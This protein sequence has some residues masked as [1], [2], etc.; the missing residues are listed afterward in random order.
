MLPALP[1]P[2]PLQIAVIVL[3]PVVPA[4]L[5]AFYVR[6]LEGHERE[7]WR[8]V[9]FAMVLGLAVGIAFLLPVALLLFEQFARESDQ[10]TSLRN[11]RGVLLLLVLLPLFEEAIKLA[12][13][14]FLKKE[15]NEVEDGLIYGVMVGAGFGIAE[16][17]IGGLGLTD[18]S[19]YLFVSLVALRGLSGV[20]LHANS[21]ALAGYGLSRHWVEK[22]SRYIVPYFLF[23]VGLHAL[24]NVFAFVQISVGG[25]DEGLL[26]LARLAFVLVLASLTF[27]YVRRRL[28]ELIKELDR[29]TDPRL[30][31]GGAQARQP[32]R[33]K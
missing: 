10:V 7:P 29:A 16:G 22:K 33:E 21:T 11:F 3:A 4:V 8:A 13:L 26:S 18:R 15:I 23:A 19:L 12:C 25:V 32:R 31:A 6:N 30:R 2:T 17:W 14:T 5:Y 1:T 9:S 20:F 27:R 28:H 24:S